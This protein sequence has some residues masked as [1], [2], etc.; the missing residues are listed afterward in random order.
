MSC[1]KVAEH[2]NGSVQRSCKTRKFGY[3]CIRE[4]LVVTFSHVTV[5]PFVHPPVRLHHRRLEVFLAGNRMATRVLV[6]QRHEKNV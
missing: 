2:K 4:I 1:S 6:K 5:R 3:P